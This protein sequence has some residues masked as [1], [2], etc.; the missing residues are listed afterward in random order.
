[1]IRGIFNNRAMRTLGGALDGLAGRQNAISSNIANAET[2][3]Y[4]RRTAPFEQQLR[5][6]LGG[7]SV[8][9]AATQPGH[10]AKASTPRSTL[11]NTPQGA[12]MLGTR[13]DANGVDIEQE[14]TDL[15]E[16][17]IRYYAVADVLKSKI[18][19]LRQVIDRA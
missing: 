17:T 11:R 19:T 12:E 15:A 9:M 3:G 16:T 4:Q 1:M 13:N 5:A 18:E 7:G 6:Q 10:I 2:P 14:M 8:S